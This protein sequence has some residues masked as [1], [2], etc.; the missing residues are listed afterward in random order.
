M[1]WEYRLR[2]GR[3]WAG[4]SGTYTKYRPNTLEKARVIAAKILEH[5]D[6][7]TYISVERNGVSI[8]RVWGGTPYCE[9]IRFADHTRHQF[10][11]RTGKMIK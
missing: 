2:V 4:M 10:D 5:G 1:T 7:D 11:P 9:W 8:G 3:D 6:G